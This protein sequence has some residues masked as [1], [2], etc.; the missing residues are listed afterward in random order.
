M[1]GS[2]RR[3]LKWPSRETAASTWT[4]PAGDGL[5]TLYVRFQD[6]RDIVTLPVSSSILLDTTPPTLAVTLAQRS[7]LSGLLSPLPE[8]CIHLPTETW[9][10]GE[11]LVVLTIS[12]L[13]FGSFGT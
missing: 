3:S 9:Q 7:R 11:L 5:K 1:V 2:S 10:R 8:A 6:F 12:V 13:T 4:F